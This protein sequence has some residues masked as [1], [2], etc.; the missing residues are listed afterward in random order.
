MKKRLF[1]MCIF[2][3][4]LLIALVCTAFATTVTEE[5]FPEFEGKLSISDRGIEMIKSIEGCINRPMSD[6]S[7]YSIGYGCSTDFAK[8]HGFSTTYL[9]EEAAHELLLFVLEGMEQKLDSFLS[10]YGIVVNQHQYDALMSF[11]FNLGSNWMNANSRLGEVLTKGNYT[12]NEFAS[13][14]G[15]YCHVTTKNGPEI[16]ELLVDRRIREIK[17]FL[18]GA[19]ELDDVDEKFCTLRFELDEGE[20]ETDI[21]FYLVGEPYQILFEAQPEE[22]SDLYF[23]GWYDE[24]GDRITAET[25]AESSSKAYAL[26]SDEEEDPELYYEGEFYVSDLSTRPVKRS[27]GDDAQTGTDGSGD[28]TVPVD[29]NLPPVDVPQEDFPLLNEASSVFSDLHQDQWY[30]DYVNELYNNGVINGYEDATFRPERTVTTGEA[31]KMIL[32]A[33]GYPE[34]EPVESHWA[35]GYLD[36]ALEYGILDSGDITDLDVPISRVMMAKVAA[37]A[38]GLERIFDV[39]PFADT[40]NVYAAVLSDHAIVEGYEDGTFRPDRSLTRA[41]L[42]TIVWRIYNYQY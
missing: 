25:I 38:L 26:W 35:R 24:N 1:S 18:Y 20:S 6:Y 32:L 2:I 37:R 28:T 19:Y 3:V 22:D 5:E 13:A 21:A 42:S 7:Q 8:S 39:E 30:Y 33:A 29:P 27:F 12:V 9:S 4:V 16:L 14:M 11:T 40:S 15:V 36:F 10:S 31:L 34:P 41:E 23:I 17:L